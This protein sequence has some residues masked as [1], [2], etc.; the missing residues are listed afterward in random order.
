MP[1]KL[2]K[3]HVGL[4]LAH[5]HL[6]QLTPPVR[7]AILG[8]VGTTV[9]FRVGASDAALLEPELSP[10]V[11]AE[12]LVSLPNYSA[13]LKLMAHGEVSRP[14]SAETLPPA[15]SDETRRLRG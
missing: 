10:E 11:S 14:F 4:V 7:D 1:P 8:N 15:V 2:R 3:Y 5:Q 13:F 12:D 9:A 6:A